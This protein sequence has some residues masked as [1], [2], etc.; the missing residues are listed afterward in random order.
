M[1][2][3]FI[4]YTKT[5]SEWAEWIAWV[6]EEEEHT[7]TFQKWDFR[8]GGN[9]VVQMQN[10]AAKADRTIAV[11]SRD[12]LRSSFAAPEWVAAFAHDPTGSNLKLVPVR[13][14]ECDPEGLLKALTYI[15]LVG[16]DESVARQRL[17]DGLRAGRAKPS[18]A[19]SFPGS[20]A[21]ARHKPALFPG[22]SLHPD[23]A[24]ESQAY[25]PK[26]RR[27]VSDID[28]RRFARQAFEEIRAYFEEALAELKREHSEVDVD[29]VL[30]S[31]TRFQAE[32]FL[33]GK[34]KSFCKI[35]LGAMFGENSIGYAEGRHM[36]DNAANE[37]LSVEID[38]GNLA[39]KATMGTSFGHLQ[40]KLDL[41]R[42]T[43]TQA[44]DYLWRRFVRPL[45][46]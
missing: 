45:E 14:R 8:P 33:N 30:E 40:A 10:A 24:A 18:L 29:M 21:A 17:M 15:D 38:K 20:P 31:A 23:V 6:L 41:Q 22:P 27:A 28:R 25:I 4:S 7:V 39:F 12:Y 16:V 42:L 35:W 37:I 34:S 3:F 19:P 11:L 1:A 32:L 5:D 9:F 2:H 26:I 44:A 36:G 43:P 46:S 13:V